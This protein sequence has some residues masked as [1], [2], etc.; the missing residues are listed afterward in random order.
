LGATVWTL[1]R[2]PLL[3]SVIPEGSPLRGEVAV[4]SGDAHEE[5]I[6]LLEDGRVGD[7]RDRSVLR[8]SVHLGQDL[9]GECLGDTEQVD[10]A[11][12]FSD[13]LGLGLGEGLDMAPGGVL[14]EGVS[15]SIDAGTL[16]VSAQELYSNPALEWP[17]RTWSACGK[18]LSNAIEQRGTNG[19]K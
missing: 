4:A 11:A 17:V 7:L 1:T 18:L 16:P 3:A 5:G 6:V 19:V 14:E 2:L 10:G 8:R 13:A 12:G 9:L 15:E